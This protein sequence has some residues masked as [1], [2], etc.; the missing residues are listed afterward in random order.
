MNIQNKNFLTESKTETLFPD[1][2]SIRRHNYPNNQK[3]FE[4]M[5]SLKEKYSNTKFQ[6]NQALDK[7]RQPQHK[8]G[9]FTYTVGGFQ[10]NKG[11]FTE[12]KKED[13]LTNEQVQTLDHFKQHVLFPTISDYQ[14]N[15]KFTLSDKDDLLY[16]N[17][18]VLYDKNSFQELHTHGASTIFTSVYFVKT[19]KK[20]YDFDGNLVVSNTKTEFVGLRHKDIEPEEGLMVT[21]P[22]DY[23][24]YVLPFHG[25]GYRAVIINDMY[26]RKA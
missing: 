22:N 12:L 5:L 23:P 17:W 20:K 14:K 16:K 7:Y 6:T 24:H 19:P 11:N 15:L 2:I 18:F 4:I 13:G 10:M 8:D 26:V 21:F 9:G 25:D 3:L 1:Y